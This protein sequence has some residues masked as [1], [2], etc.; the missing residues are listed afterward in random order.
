MKKRKAEQS[1]VKKPLKE[2]KR[3]IELPLPDWS[4]T[5]GD[6]TVPALGFGLLV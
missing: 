6:R 5:I 2:A 4:V 1:E 3:E